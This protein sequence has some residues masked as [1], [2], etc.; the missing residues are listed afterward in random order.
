MREKHRRWLS[1][2]GILDKPW[3][4]FGSAPDPTL[5]SGL[6]ERCARVDINNAGKTASA[7]GLG[8]ADLTI[9]KR[10]KSWK[11]HPNLQTRG[12]LWYH[13]APLSMM[14]LR[15]WLKPGVRF[16]SLKRATKDERNA[17]VHLVCGGVPEELGETG[18]VTN[19]VA[20]ACYALYMGVPAVV[21]AGISLSKM[22]HSYDDRGRRRRQ[23][24]EDAF[25]LQKLRNVRNLFTTETD[26]A[27]RTGI[28]LASGSSCLAVGRASDL[29]A[30][31][32]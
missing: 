24:D 11:E 30:G 9:R 14:Y 25:V 20:A 29:Q 10:K 32:A 2:L 13:T 5:P 23:I 19:G 17:I 3:L 27:A 16:K 7:L 15:L 12:L 4:I 18:K 31:P 8:P 28:R 22:G 26:L 6:V 1:K 21:L